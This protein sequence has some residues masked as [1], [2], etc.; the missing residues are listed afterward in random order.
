[1]GG[2]VLVVVRD[3]LNFL[4]LSA[5]LFPTLMRTV[6]PLLP[7]PFLV[8]SCLVFVTGTAGVEVTLSWWMVAESGWLVLI[9]N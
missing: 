6:I 1:M 8:P 5:T 7:P 9:D 3:F 2:L 4:V